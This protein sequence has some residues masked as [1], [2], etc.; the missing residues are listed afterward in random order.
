M[1][2]R[3]STVPPSER[4]RIARTYGIPVERV[5]ER[6]TVC[7]P[8]TYA[9]DAT[10]TYHWRDGIENH[11]A[12]AARQRRFAEAGERKEREVRYREMVERGLTVRQ[13]AAELGVSRETARDHLKAFGLRAA[14]NA[15]RPNGGGQ[16]RT[17]PALIRAMVADGLTNVE[18]AERTGRTPKAISNALGRLGLKANKPR[19]P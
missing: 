6:V 10:A 8:R 12:A 11:R 1:T 4:E 9:H 14:S 2:S 3:M 19:R 5:P 7:P 13:I 18:I 16:W 17:D 15:A